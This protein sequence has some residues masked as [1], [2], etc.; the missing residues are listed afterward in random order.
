MRATSD[1]VIK[2]LMARLAGR[3]GLARQRKC[4]WPTPD[5]LVTLKTNADNETRAMTIAKTIWKAPSREKLNLY[6]EI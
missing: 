6:D 1:R 5:D 3:F 4:H 2:A